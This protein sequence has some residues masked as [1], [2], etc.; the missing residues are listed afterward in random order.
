[1]KYNVHLTKNDFYRTYDYFFNL[2]GNK[3]KSSFYIKD[4]S[5][6]ENIPVIFENIMKNF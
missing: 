1:M 3:I 4:K 2:N 6:K 5:H